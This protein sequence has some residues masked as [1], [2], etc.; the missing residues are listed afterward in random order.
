MTLCSLA[1]QG[2]LQ[3]LNAQERW[4]APN[5]VAVVIIVLIIAVVVAVV[6]II[7]KHQNAEY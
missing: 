5:T 7:Q 3:F 1:L 6:N 4:E 2:S